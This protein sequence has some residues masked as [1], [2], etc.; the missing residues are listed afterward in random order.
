MKK[1]N[2]SNKGLNSQK[3]IY[4]I[5][6]LCFPLFINAQSVLYVYG[7]VSADGD[8]PSGDKAPFQQMR[9]N[10]NGNEGMSQFLEALEEVKLKVSEVYDQEIEFTSKRLKN[11]DVL[12][13]ASN[14][15]MFS[16]DEA[17]AVYNWVKKGGGLVCWSDSAFGG[18][19]D[20]VGVDNP[21][22][23]D[24]DN[25][26]ME[27]FGMHFLVDNGAGN[28]LVKDY[29]QNHFLN[30]NNKDGGVRFRGEGV[31][32]VRV[33]PPAIVLA[34]AQEGGLGG[35]LWVNKKDGKLNIETDAAL[36]IAKK[37][38][39]RVVGL[40]DRNLFWNAGGGTRI[41]HSDNKEFTQR[42]MLYA[43]GIED[44]NRIPSRKNKENTGVNNPP[45]IS[46][47]YDLIENTFVKVTTIIKDKDTDQ[48]TPEINWKQIEGPADGIFENNNP[49]TLTPVIELPENGMYKF[50]ATIN[51]GEFHFTKNIKIERN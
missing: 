31:S 51:D 4:L 40:F 47:D 7:D 1:I 23:R 18:K 21:L 2:K 11:V 6:V 36:A 5:M 19:Y 16:K 10:D 13:L 12:I 46:I 29:T 17:K 39:G 44:E 20:V 33:S 38:K 49:N 30:A 14:Q 15:R 22:G 32:F 42:L 28:Y 43:A 8:I 25:I 26:I 50:Q 41:S 45:E 34:K 24:S 37:G 27:Q 3:I 35:K 9:L 48:I